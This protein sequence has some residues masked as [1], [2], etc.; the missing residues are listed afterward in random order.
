MKTVQL[1]FCVVFAGLPFIAQA[2]WLSDITGIDIN[3]P[4]GTVEVHT[5]RPQDI[6]QMLQNLPKDVGQALLNPLGAV[7]AT[8]IRQAAAQ[9]RW[10]A[11]PI[12]AEIRNVLSPYFS[13]NIL[14]KALWNVYD[15]NRITVDSAILGWFQNEGAVT[16]DNVVVFSNSNE[17]QNNWQLWAHAFY[18]THLERFSLILMIWQRALDTGARVA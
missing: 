18:Y 7:L 13:P 2:S 16:L 1:Y 9:A 6:P 17:A 11:Q 10:G 4:A 15:P 12:P 14:N 5:P 8:T 3:I